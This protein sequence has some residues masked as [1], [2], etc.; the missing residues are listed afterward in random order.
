MRPLTIVDALKLDARRVP[1]VVYGEE[2]ITHL[3]ICTMRLGSLRRCDS[4]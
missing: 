4:K 2:S 3:I 1:D